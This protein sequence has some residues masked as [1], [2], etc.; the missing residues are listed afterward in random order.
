ML[1]STQTR[2]VEAVRDIR[3]AGG[4]ATGGEIAARLGMNSRPGSQL[5]Q[6]VALGVLE[7]PA[8]GSNAGYRWAPRRRAALNDTDRRIFAAIRQALKEDG[9]ATRAAVAYIAGVADG[10]VTFVTQRLEA[11]GYI[12]RPGVRGRG[13][14]RPTRRGLR[15]LGGAA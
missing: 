12:D 6:L 7:P 5:A 2:I 9:A 11:F 15:A 10:T 4:A 3:A 8:F 14:Y 1:T 13:G